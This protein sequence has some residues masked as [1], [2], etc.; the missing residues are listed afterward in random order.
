[1]ESNFDFDDFTLKPSQLYANRK[2]IER[3]LLQ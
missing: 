2:N 1:M 3:E